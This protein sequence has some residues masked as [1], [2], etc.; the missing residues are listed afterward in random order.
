MQGNRTHYRSFDIYNVTD[1]QRDEIFR[2][3]VRLMDRGIGN[4]KIGDGYV[5][6]YAQCD[7]GKA[8]S[9]LN[10]YLQKEEIL[11]PAMKSLLIFFRLKC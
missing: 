9:A 5:K 10:D 3:L 7:C 2:F 8:I 6:A 4:A 1:V 11:Q